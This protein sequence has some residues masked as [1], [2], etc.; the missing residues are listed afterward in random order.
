[1]P[2]YEYICDDCEHYFTELKT[3]AE[4]DSPSLCPICQQAGRKIISAPRLNTMRSEIRKAYET[5]ER[6]A[7]SPRV[8]HKHE[9]GAHCHHHHHKHEESKPEYKQQVNSRPW[10]LG[11]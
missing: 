10:M 4:F 1:M 2:V 11:H 3:F 5:N 7:D 8:H 9:C 6:S